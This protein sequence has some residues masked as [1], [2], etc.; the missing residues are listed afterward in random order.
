M[1]GSSCDGLDMAMCHIE[2][3]SGRVKWEIIDSIT[4]PYSPTWKKSLQSAASCTGYELMK[5]DAALGEWIGHEIKMWSAGKNWDVDYIASHGH[6]VFHEPALGFTTQ[7]GSG[8]HIAEQTCLPVLTSFR[9][10]DVAHGGQG[11]PF[12]PIAD[13]ALFEGYDAY[14]NLGGIANIF[15]RSSDDQ[16][17]AWDIGPC[18]QALNH[19]AKKSG[20]EFDAGGILASQGAVL[21]AVRHDLVAM[22]PFQG[23]IPRSLS[24]KQIQKTWI[25]YLDVRTEDAAD[26]QSTATLA[27]ADMIT[28]HLSPILIRPAKILVTGGGAHNDHLLQLLRRLG[29]DFG[30]TY[31]V[32]SHQIVDYKESLLMA[33][34][35]YLTM[36]D[37]PFGTH[38]FTGASGDCIG[39]V[40]HKAYR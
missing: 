38:L 30:Y 19:L 32:P 21:D 6:T 5:L 16:W 3:V 37:K 31:E 26:L 13:R 20:H 39:G 25:E 11:A 2:E 40:L 17:H 4:I 34:L 7:I 9:T 8:A 23:G 28:L 35:G 1:S 27:V 24:N 15:L 36:H 29:T 22:Y 18:N 12:A 33:Y 10:A 14:L